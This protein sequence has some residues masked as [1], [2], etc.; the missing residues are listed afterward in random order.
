M[1]KCHKINLM[2][3]NIVLP[4]SGLKSRVLS[5]SKKFHLFSELILTMKWPENKGFSCNIILMRYSISFVHLVSRLWFLC[6]IIL[7]INAYFFPICTKYKYLFVSTKI[8]TTSLADGDAT[9]GCDIYVYTLE[10]KVT[11][12]QFQCLRNITGKNKRIS[13]RCA[14]QLF[15]NSL[16]QTL[17]EGDPVV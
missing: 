7:F 1:P 15:R 13:N 14:T 12:F 17:K 16:F 6:V 5:A 10:K 2:E 8:C 9:S 11:L 3:K 4:V